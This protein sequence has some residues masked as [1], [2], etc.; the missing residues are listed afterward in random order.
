MN[1]T[2]QQHAQW[3]EKQKLSKMLRET[4][5][6]KR[7]L[8][9]IATFFI[10]MLFI[11]NIYALTSVFGVT[12]YVSEGFQFANGNEFLY[13]ASEF[14]SCALPSIYKSPEKEESTLVDLVFLADIAAYET[15]VSNEMIDQWFESDVSNLSD[16]V[17]KFKKAYAEEHA[18]SAATYALIDFPRTD[19]KIISV[20]GTKNAWDILHDAQIWMPV[21]LFQVVLSVIPFG[22][23]FSPFL[24]YMIEAVSRIE[25]RALKDISYYKEISSF[26]ESLKEE[27]LN[28][29]I[30]G[31]CKYKDH[32]DSVLNIYI[33]LISFS[34]LPYF[35]ALGGGT[36]MIS[37]TQTK[38]PS[39]GLS[40]I[41]I[42]NTRRTFDPPLSIDDINK[43]TFNI[44][45]DKDPVPL[46]DK[47][48]R[49][50]KRIN[51][52]ADQNDWEN[53]CHLP[54]SSLCEVLYTCG[55]FNRPIP[56]ECVYRFGYEKPESVNG[57][58][59]ADACNQ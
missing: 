23:F 18:G 20:L 15:N 29:M 59:F 12:H 46:I 13:K 6:D 56:C 8:F 1:E 45:P 7:R 54:E 11:C 21:I 19:M 49:N 33:D 35:S 36:A 3:K 27:G 14:T 51:C 16:Q 58:D 24:P 47:L 4:S 10:L 31:H 38:V 28:M 39:L 37:G 30:V 55:S 42:I 40:G 43:F 44:K 5:L 22:R 48:P 34:L 57:L 41:N 32:F 52:R 9:W 53:F 2:Q 50:F 25:G 17:D 26:V